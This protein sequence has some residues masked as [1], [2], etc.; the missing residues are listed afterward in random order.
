MAAKGRAVLR[1][2]TMWCSRGWGG[3]G[4]G[5]CFSGGDAGNNGPYGQYPDLREGKFEVGSTRLQ[6]TSTNFGPP[7]SEIRSAV[8]SGGKIATYGLRQLRFRSIFSR[9]LVT[10]KETVRKLKSMVVGEYGCADGCL[11]CS[12]RVGKRILTPREIKARAETRFEA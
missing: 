9:Y 12:L 11:P 8:V 7:V 3:V 5:S 4:G 10:G 2:T 1:C 6:C